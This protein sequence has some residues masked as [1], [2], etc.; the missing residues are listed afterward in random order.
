M[1]GGDLLEEGGRDER[2]ALAHDLVVEVGE[3]ELPA[4]VRGRGLGGRDR[5]QL[6]EVLARCADRRRAEE[7][8]QLGAGD[9]LAARGVLLGLH[10]RLDRG[11]EDHGVGEVARGAEEDAMG[12]AEAEADLG[13]YLEGLAEELDRGEATQPL[14]DV[15]RAARGPERH[16]GVA[17]CAVALEA[18]QDGVARELIDDAA[19]GIEDVDHLGEVARQE[20]LQGVDAARSGRAHG[21]DHGREAGDV[22]EEHGALERLDGREC[23]VPLARELADER[24]R[25]VGD[26]GGQCSGF[27]HTRT[28][29]EE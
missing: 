23:G 25:D 15:E 12:V 7:P 18:A 14:L 17:L 13:R 6:V 5:G 3:R 28:S 20:L 11:A 29:H 2:R 9:H 1:A 24:R 27:S 19:E 26:D 10:G 4:G 22:E 21:H 8:P 16:D